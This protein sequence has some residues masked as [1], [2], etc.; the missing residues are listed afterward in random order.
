MAGLVTGAAAEGAP[1]AR[2]VCDQG[3]ATLATGIRLVGGCFPDEPVLVALIG[4]VVR[5]PF[6]SRAV[7]QVLDRNANRRYQIVEPVLSS[8]QGAVLMALERW[9]KVIEEPLVRVLAE[10]SAAVSLCQK[11]DQQSPFSS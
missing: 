1:V 7:E 8:V 10:S 5:S 4:G 3:A 2:A 11:G 9:G 6:M